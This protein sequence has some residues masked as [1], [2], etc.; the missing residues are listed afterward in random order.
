MARL[1]RCLPLLLLIPF[2]AMLFPSLYNRATPEIAGFPFFYAWQFAWI[3]L[4]AIIT[5]IVHRGSRA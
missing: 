3:V 4:A 1:R 2:A 5:W